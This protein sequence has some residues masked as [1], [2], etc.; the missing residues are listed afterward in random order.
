MA[1]FGAEW[2]RKQKLQPRFRHTCAKP[3]MERSPWTW[4]YGL[5]LEDELGCSKKEA[6]SVK[7]N[8]VEA[9]AG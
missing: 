2:L 3:L 7:G 1:H 9:K 8:K 4:K 5:A 6:A